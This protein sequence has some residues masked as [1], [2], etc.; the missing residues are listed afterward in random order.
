MEKYKLN[1]KSDIKLNN[2]LYTI[3]SENNCEMERIMLLEDMPRL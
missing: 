3:T 1:N 2:I